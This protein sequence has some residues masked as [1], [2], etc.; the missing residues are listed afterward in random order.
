MNDFEQA[1]KDANPS[2]KFEGGFVPR[3]RFGWPTIRGNQVSGWRNRYMVGEQVQVVGEAVPVSQQQSIQCPPTTS[4]IHVIF[5]DVTPCPGVDS[6]PEYNGAIPDGEYDLEWDGIS[7]WRNV[8]TGGVRI[9]WA[10]GNG[11][12]QLSVDSNDDYGNSHTVFNTPT[13]NPPLS[14]FSADNVLECSGTIYEA[15]PG[16]PPVYRIDGPGAFG[17]TVTYAIIP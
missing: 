2:C 14:M 8:D 9:G 17:G 12:W 7:T 6:A 10:C 4:I 13:V 16:P 3:A 11:S 1:L 15:D 5:S